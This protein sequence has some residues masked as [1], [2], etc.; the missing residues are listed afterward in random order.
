M[1]HFAKI[2]NGI[3]EQVIVINNQVL[4]DESNIE[5]ESRGINF[6]NNTLKLN[7]TWKQTSY[8]NN[9]R[10]KFASVGYIYDE[11]NDVFYEPQP[12]A[13]WTLD[14]NYNWQPPLLPPNDGNIY[15]WN[16]ETQSWDL[17]E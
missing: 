16:E 12:Y 11:V 15:N 17:V 3:V 2:N 4:L 8:N 14:E 1:A 7:G 5:Q 10:N 9:I 13:S 6:I